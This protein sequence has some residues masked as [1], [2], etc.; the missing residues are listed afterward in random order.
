MKLL[1]NILRLF[2]S[3]QCSAISWFLFAGPYLP[4]LSLVEQSFIQWYGL[5]CMSWSS[6]S[7]AV[8]PNVEAWGNKEHF[9]SREALAI[10][11]NKRTKKSCIIYFLW[12]I[13]DGRV[14][15]S[16]T[17]VVQLLLAM[18]NSGQ[19]WAALGGSRRLWAALGS[20]GQ[21]WAAPDG[22]GQPKATLAG[23]THK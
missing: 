16:T 6:I 13:H 12:N 23:H 17:R 21:L 2:F 10:V 20:S 7:P 3:F 4:I 15:K 1:R 9:S 5:G 19:L 22:P 8:F 14:L 18:M 11:S